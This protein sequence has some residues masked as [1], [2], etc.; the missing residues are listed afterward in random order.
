MG[1]FNFFSTKEEIPKKSIFDLFQIDL[2]KL[3]DDRFYR[4]EFTSNSEGSEFQICVFTP[5]YLECGIFNTIIIYL[6]KHGLY[7]VIFE[8]GDSPTLDWVKLK[9][10]VNSICQIYGHDYEGKGNVSYQ[11]TSEYYG[12][13]GFFMRTWMKKEPFVFI[14]VNHDNNNITLTI[15]GIDNYSND[16]GKIK[17]TIFDFFQTDLK[18]LPDSRFNYDGIIHN[19]SGEQIH[20]Y[21]T[22]IDYLECSIFNEI[23]VYQF[24]NKRINVFFRCKDYSNVNIRYL[25]KL[26]NDLFNIYGDDSN[27]CG[28]FT[29]ED[30]KECNDNDY[31]SFRRFWQTDTCYIGIDIDL[32][33]NEIALSLLGI[34]FPE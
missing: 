9:S 6:F 8:S 32:S 26:T 14:S 31:V 12:I 1:L 4:G 18:E 10:V 29:E 23:E 5:D 17:E 21:S 27:E 30:R 33:E 13:L 25:E 19:N 22:I 11:D 7:N 16:K 28:L 15:S 2:K 24:E 34:D 3:P 20:V